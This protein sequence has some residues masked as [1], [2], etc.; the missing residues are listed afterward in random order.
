[1]WDRYQHNEQASNRYEC[2]CDA[3]KGYYL[4]QIEEAN[5]LSIFPGLGA[6]II[7]RGGLSIFDIPTSL[8]VREVI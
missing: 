1:M 3:C 7:S 8:G 4:H 5:R 6:L 2:Q